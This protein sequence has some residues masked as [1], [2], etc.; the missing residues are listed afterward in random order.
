VG[1]KNGKDLVQKLLLKGAF[2]IAGSL[3]LVQKN[4]LHHLSPVR[5]FQI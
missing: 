5:E 4:V 3:V 1:E 2:R